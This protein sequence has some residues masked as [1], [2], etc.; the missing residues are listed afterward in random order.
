MNEIRKDFFEY[1]VKK[2]ELSILRQSES[3]I[4]F[5]AKKSIE[6]AEIGTA[7]IDF[8]E[9][10]SYSSKKLTTGGFIFVKEKERVIVSVTNFCTKAPFSI[11][12]SVEIFSSFKP[13]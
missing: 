5:E 6:S 9:K 2:F 3:K 11:T 7:V 8:F 12:V 4:H 1:F 13:T 10:K